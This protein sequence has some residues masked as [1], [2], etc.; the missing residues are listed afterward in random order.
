MTFSRTGAFSKMNQNDILFWWVLITSIVFA[1]L[2]FRGID[3][4]CKKLSELNYLNS[5]ELAQY[6]SYFGE[7]KYVGSS[8]WTSGQKIEFQ[9]IKKWCPDFFK[10]YSKNPSL[11]FAKTKDAIAFINEKGGISICQKE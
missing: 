10:E 7:I 5:L 2:I 4:R 3:E 1:V 9:E 8:E 11:S 6:K